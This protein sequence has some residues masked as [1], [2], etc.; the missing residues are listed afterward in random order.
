MGMVTTIVVAMLGSNALFGLI[1]YLI[2]RYFDR[3]DTIRQTLAAVAYT[4]L[5]D[6]IEE[7]LDAD[8][9]TPEQRKELDILY[10]AYKA[11]GWNGDMDTRIQKVYNLPTKKIS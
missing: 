9:A 5:S 8:Y 7:R 3:K 1:T 10:E 11:N 4:A 2:S 6:K